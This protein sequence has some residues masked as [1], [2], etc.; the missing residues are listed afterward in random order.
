[1]TVGDRLLLVILRGAAVHVIDGHCPYQYQPLE[2]GAVDADGVI[3]GPMHGWR[4]RLDTGLS[5]DMPWTSVQCFPA[6][7]EDGQ[8][9]AEV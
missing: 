7:L 1:M 3:I 2:D 6:W 4:F 5:P 8:V 9:W